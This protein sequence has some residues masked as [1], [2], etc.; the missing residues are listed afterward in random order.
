[1]M[2]RRVPVIAASTIALV[3]AASAPAV[4]APTAA[5]AGHK[6]VGDSFERS[7]TG[8]KKTTAPTRLDRVPAGRGKR[9]Q[10]ARLRSPATRAANVGITDA[11]ALVRRS[12]RGARY[13]A[14][15]WVKATPD[16]HRGGALQVRVSLGELKPRGL[17]PRAWRGARLSTSKWRKVTVPFT[18]RHKG[19][20]LDLTVRASSLPRGG[21]LLVDDIRIQKVKAPH[22]SNRKLRGV[23]YGA[24]VD[25]GRLDWIRALH[26]SDRLYSH[27]EVVR[28]FE[29]FIRDSWSGTLGHVRRPVNVSFSA[30]PGLVLAGAYDA[31][32]RKWF[33]DAPNKTP[34]WWTYWH[35]PEDDIARGTLSAK[36]YRQAWRHINA[37]ARQAGTPNLHPTL[38]LMSWTGQPA[39]GRRISDYYP[40]RFIDVIGWDGYNPPGARGYASP[41]AMFAACVAKNRRLD[42]RFAI[43]ELGS[44][45]VPGDDG[46]R[47]ASWLVQVAKYAAARNAAFVTYWDAKI[48]NEN[49]QLRDLPS[50]SAWRHVVKD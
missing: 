23:R 2:S 48:P 36:R 10:A 13:V 46:S 22:A 4:L 25:E 26:K 15:A 37:I 21:A 31:T 35:E 1:M 43:P 14:T 29:P 3:V 6:L 45:L 34:I 11:P 8:W 20:H 28:F 30:R 9:S 7:L 49:Y 39:S 42:A 19:R 47:R 17:G 18:A 40:G 41:R 44:V 33:R 27:M 38:V 16:A 12:H 24:S 50:R 32:L 5:V